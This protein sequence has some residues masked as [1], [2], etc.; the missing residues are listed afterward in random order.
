MERVYMIKKDGRKS[1]SRGAPWLLSFRPVGMREF[2]EDGQRRVVYTCLWVAWQRDAKIFK[3]EDEARRVARHIGGCI[4][5]RVNGR[6][7]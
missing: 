1:E 7:E 3:N 4:V 6:M 2:M 5:I